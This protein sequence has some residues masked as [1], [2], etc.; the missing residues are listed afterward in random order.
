[1]NPLLFILSGCTVVMALYLLSRKVP[2]LGH[3]LGFVC[4]VASRIPILLALCM[5]KAAVY[6]QRSRLASLHLHPGGNGDYWEGVN[7]LSRLVYVTLAVCILAG[8]TVNTLLVLPALWQIAAQQSP[9]EGALTGI[10]DIASAALFISCPAFFGAIIFECWRKIPPRAGLFL[11]LGIWSRRILGGLSGVLLLFTIAVNGYFYLF[12]AVYLADPQAAQGMVLYILGGLGIEVAAVS[13]FAVLALGISGAGVVS[14]LLL[15]G[16]YVCRITATGVALVPSLLDVVAIHFTQGTMSVYDDAVVP[17]SSP[18]PH[19]ARTPYLLAVN[20]PRATHEDKESHA[21]ED[22]KQTIS[23]VGYGSVGRRFLPLLFE[24]AESVG[25]TSRLFKA[26]L[27]DLD[28]PYG[29]PPI[30][31]LRRGARTITPSVTDMRNTQTMETIGQSAYGALAE[32]MHD[33]LVEASIEKQI[34]TGTIL[35]ATPLSIIPQLTPALRSLKNRLPRQTIILV[36]ERSI[37][38]T[39]E[40]VTKGREALAT[41]QKEGVIATAFLLDVTDKVAVQMGAEAMERACAQ[42]LLGLTIAP[43]HSDQNP[44]LAAVANCLGDCEP[45]TGMTCHVLPVSHGQSRPLWRLVK[46]FVPA[47]GERG[48][49]DYPDILNQAI[50]ATN[51]VINDAGVVINDIGVATNGT[52][53]PTRHDGG[54]TFPRF[55]VYSIPLHSADSKFAR[56]ARDIRVYCANTVRTKQGDTIHPVLISANGTPVPGE[57]M[58]YRVQATCLYPLA[59]KDYVAIPLSQSREKTDGRLPQNVPADD[60]H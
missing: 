11:H 52:G 49:G 4:I 20:S 33:S 40:A 30:P 37:F 1:M 14:L 12:R 22:A 5:Q 56:F 45:L 43:I 3:A 19:H 47:A 6:C 38:E 50:A 54:R 23:I 51:A 60:M 26:G 32:K 57:G 41:L 36:T 53:T 31:S 42:T 59:E 7:V 25:A 17:G 46:R 35:V 15:F 9:L 58:G 55:V 27:V 2:S 18:A 28:S 24:A 10:V 48:F 39:R 44:S 34:H 8:E 13:P 29:T 16:E 21:M